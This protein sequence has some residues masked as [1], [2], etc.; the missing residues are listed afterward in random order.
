MLSNFLE[1]PSPTPDTRTKDRNLSTFTSIRWLYRIYPSVLHKPFSAIA[2]ER[3]A[4]WLSNYDNEEDKRLH[5]SPT[6]YRWK[7]LE[8]PGADKRVTFIEGVVTMGGA[9][10]PSSKVK[11]SFIDLHSLGSEFI[12]MLVMPVWRRK[13]SILQ[14]VIS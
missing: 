13:L 8:M 7:P 6:Q 9:G 14:M 12:C 1:P 11:F 5:V 10:T 4:Q 2:E 3:F